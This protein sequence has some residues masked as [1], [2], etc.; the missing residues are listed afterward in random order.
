MFVCGFFCHFVLYM[1]TKNKKHAT[2]KSEIPFYNKVFMQNKLSPVRGH[3]YIEE[4]MKCQ[5]KRWS[6][7]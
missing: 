2:L 3:T 6:N 4:G 1:C 7:F 5:A